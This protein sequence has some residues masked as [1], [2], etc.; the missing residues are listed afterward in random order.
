MS[1]L[2]SFSKFLLF[3]LIPESDETRWSNLWSFVVFKDL[4]VDDEEED[5]SKQPASTERS[6]EW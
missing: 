1:A 3:G 5:V 4:F 6:E 2:K